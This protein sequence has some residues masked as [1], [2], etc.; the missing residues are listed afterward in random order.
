MEN[1]L[2]RERVASRLT[3]TLHR[4]SR[5]EVRAFELSRCPMHEDVKMSVRSV[6]WMKREAVD[7]AIARFQE[8]LHTVRIQVVAQADHARWTLLLAPL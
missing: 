5:N 6:A 8:W 2:L 1:P 3:L 4:E 7:Q